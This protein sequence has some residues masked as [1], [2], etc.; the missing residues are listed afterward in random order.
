MDKSAC[1][2]F[3]PTD[4]G[5][6]VNFSNYYRDQINSGGTNEIPIKSKLT[7]KSGQTILAASV[8]FWKVDRIITT[9]D[10]GT[11]ETSVKAIYLYIKTNE[12]TVTFNANSGSVSTSTKTV[13]I[14]EKYGEL[15]TPTAPAGYSFSGWYTSSSGGSKVTSDTTVPDGNHTLYAQWTPNNYTATFN[16]NGGQWSDNAVKKEVS[17]TFGSQ[18]TA[19][20]NP[21]RTGYTFDGWNPTVGSMDA[22]GKTFTA[23]WK[24]NTYDVTFNSEGGSAVTGVTVTYDSNDNNSE[25]GIPTRT[26]YTFNGWFTAQSDGIKVYDKDGNSVKNT[27]YWTADG[28]WI[29]TNNVELHAQWTANTYDAT[30]KAN[31]GQWSDNAVTKVVST[32]FDSA[33]TVPDNPTRIGYTFDKWDPTVG[34]MNEEG[35]I[36]TAQWNPISYTIK[37]INGNS[38]INTQTERYGIEFNL[39]TIAELTLTPP[40]GKH[41]VGWNSI[42]ADANTIMY[43][44]GQQITTGLTTENGATVMLYPVWADNDTYRVIYNPNGGVGVVSDTA[45]YVTGAD[46]TVNFTSVPT[47]TGYKFAGWATTSNAT[48]A[49]YT[50]TSGGT[51]S[52]KMGTNDVTLYAVWNPIQYIVEYNNNDVTNTS[53]TFTYDVTGALSNGTGF[54]R[55]G[56]ILKGWSLSAGSKAIAYALGETVLNL[57]NVDGT[58]ITLY[59]VWQPDKYT[60]KYVTGTTASINNQ[61]CAYD[62]YVTINN[63][64]LSKANYIFKGWA[65]RE[66]SDIVAY[67][68]GQTVMNI[69]DEDHRE[70]TLYAVWQGIDVEVTFDGNGGTPSTNT[71]IY[72][73][74]KIFSTLPNA[75]RVGYIFNGWYTAIESDTK[76]VGTSVVGTDAVVNN[77]KITLYAHWTATN[78]GYTVHHY[79]QMQDND[80]ALT[81]TEYLTGTTGETAIATEKTYTG[82]TYN[83]DKSIASGTIEADGSLVLKLYYDRVVD[84]YSVSFDPNGGSFGTETLLNRK[85]CCRQC[86]HAPRE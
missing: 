55:E 77:G 41:F 73:Y 44:D 43:A 30:F 54:S 19:P 45:S 6:D 33:I 48:E 37:Y 85:L 62:A 25:I 26:G 78:V 7:N 27:T 76:I 39:K 40:T 31:G 72:T 15:P 5:D 71:G 80:Y 60:I 23:Q 49:T 10:A 17:T 18:I 42:S 36:F 16:A 12:C 84:T 8:E 65:L 2:N 34:N 67:A 75:S 14:G 59:A 4:N 69:T 58:T 22:E 52:F 61:E 50:S 28:N 9:T 13:T 63:E 24:A 47:R 83:I 68:P 82:F 51:T 21:S 32:K 46:V 3:N 29:Y 38:I 66:G 53:N 20:A 1:D 64:S 57:T 70:I 11:N 86:Y 81:E 56:Y 35:K 74:G 79:T